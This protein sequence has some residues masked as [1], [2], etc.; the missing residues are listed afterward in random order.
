VGLRLG[1]SIF[2]LA[3][4]GCSKPYS[5]REPKA[6]TQRWN[7]ISDITKTLLSLNQ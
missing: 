5:R 1:K 3:A 4:A 2:F 7:Q 6:I